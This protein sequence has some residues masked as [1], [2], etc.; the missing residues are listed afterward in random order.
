MKKYKI[1][2]DQYIEVIGKKLYRIQALKDFNGVKA[3]D[4]GGYIENESNLSQSG[5]A[6]VYGDAQV[7]GKKQSPLVAAGWTESD[8]RNWCEE[9]DLLS[10]IYTTATRGGC[11]FCHNQSIRQLRLLRRDYPDLW[12]LMLKWD[13]DSPITFK[14]DGHTVHD[15]D[16]RFALEDMGLVPM[17]GTFRWSMISDYDQWP[18]MPEALRLRT[19]GGDINGK[20]KLG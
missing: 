14:A 15:Y 4:V 8:C 2:K 11:W 7:C 13:A 5:N 19:S 6:W 16:R 17:A 1:L 12:A 9:N 18:I 3:G 10:P 20:S